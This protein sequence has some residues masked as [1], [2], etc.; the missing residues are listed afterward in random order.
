MDVNRL[1]RQ[2]AFMDK[3]DPD[4]AFG[5]AQLDSYDAPECCDS[6]DEPTYPV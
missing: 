3:Y 2:E 4:S 6:D 5:T 1:Y